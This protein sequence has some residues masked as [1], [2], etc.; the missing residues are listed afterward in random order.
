MIAKND[1]DELAQVNNAPARRWLPYRFPLSADD[2]PTYMQYPGVLHRYRAGG[3]PAQ[4]LWSFFALHTE[5]VN[6]WT[7]FLSMIF[8]LTA[9]TLAFTVFRSPAFIAYVFFCTASIIHTPFSIGFHLLMPINISVFNLWRRL[10]VIAIFL[11]S[12][13]FTVSLSLVILPWWGTL[14]TGCVS[15]TL[16]VVASNYFWTMPDHHALD[17]HK[18]SMFVGSIIL[19]YWFPMFFAFVRD[20]IHGRFGVSSAMVLGEVT[21]LVAG[22]TAFAYSWPQKYAP[23]KYDVFG[24]SHSMLHVA[25]M[26]AHVCKFFFIFV[27]SWG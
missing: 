4:C 2:A 9:S 24:H 27:N 6:A 20:A 12:T 15:L 23:G 5:T 3:T 25:A 19:C 18:H 7:V 22:G 11:G 17:N 16:A 8:A 1:K 21:T 13:C 26:F 10:D 14:T